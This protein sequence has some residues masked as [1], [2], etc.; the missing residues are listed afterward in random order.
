MKCKSF[1][2]GLQVDDVHFTT[3]ITFGH[4]VIKT[5]IFRQHTCFKVYSAILPFVMQSLSTA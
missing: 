1:L 4:L 3:A 5:A 2:N